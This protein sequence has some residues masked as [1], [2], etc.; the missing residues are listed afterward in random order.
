MERQRDFERLSAILGDDE[1]DEQGE[2]VMSFMKDERLTEDQKKL[3]TEIRRKFDPQEIVADL[4]ILY[5]T[6]GY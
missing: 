4:C 1:L 5:E 6:T 3:L 2:P